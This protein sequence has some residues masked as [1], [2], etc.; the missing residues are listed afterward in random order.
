MNKD[1]T[2]YNRYE[3]YQRKA[4][5]YVGK[6]IISKTKDKYKKNTRRTNAINSILDNV[7]DG[8]KDLSKDL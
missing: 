2:K 1:V 4:A 8:V 3:D 6:K 7:R 5:N